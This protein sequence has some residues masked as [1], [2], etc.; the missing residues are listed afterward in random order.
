M[1]STKLLSLCETAFWGLRW[2]LYPSCYSHQKTLMQAN[3]ALCTALQPHTTSVPL[4]HLRSTFDFAKKKSN[5]LAV[6]CRCFENKLTQ[7][8]KGGKVGFF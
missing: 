3:M 7:Q 4:Q 1:V 6:M 2:L 8:G 5:C